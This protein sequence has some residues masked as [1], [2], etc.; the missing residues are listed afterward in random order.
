M[1]CRGGLKR[2][3][4][5]WSKTWRA[6]IRTRGHGLKATSRITSEVKME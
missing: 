3:A 6:L 4:N 1:E 2:R 5:R